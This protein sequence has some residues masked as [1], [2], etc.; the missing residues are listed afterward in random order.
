MLGAM[1]AGI[2]RAGEIVS[3]GEAWQ[4]RPFPQVDP[5]KQKMPNI[6]S[7]ILISSHRSAH[8]TELIKQ[9]FSTILIELQNKL[10]RFSSWLWLYGDMFYLPSD[11]PFFVQVLPHI[12]GQLQ[13]SC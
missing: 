11:H 9:P 6:F 7:F 1:P 2:A 4:N 5:I 8:A 13:L 3:I 12:T 10:H